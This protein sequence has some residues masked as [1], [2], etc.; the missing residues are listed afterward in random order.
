MSRCTKTLLGGTEEDT[1]NTA[2]PPSGTVV[3]NLPKVRSIK[4]LYN[5][6]PSGDKSIS[7]WYNRT[8][9]RER[10]KIYGPTVINQGPNS[11][12]RWCIK[13]QN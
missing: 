7:E 10:T 8:C 1:D 9:R 13:Y 5:T 12:P 11:T 3:Q 2:V 4:R 6:T